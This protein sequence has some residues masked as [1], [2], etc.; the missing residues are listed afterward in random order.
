MIFLC[1]TCRESES[2]LQ[3]HYSGK[4]IGSGGA[5][6]KAM[7]TATNENDVEMM[8]CQEVQLPGQ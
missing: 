2:S 8:R 1:L 6:T 3:R 7:L 4:P 5:Q